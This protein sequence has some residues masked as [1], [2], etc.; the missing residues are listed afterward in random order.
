M[1]SSLET[2]ICHGC[3]PKKKKKRKRK[4]KKKI[5]AQIN[6][7]QTKKTIERSMMK[8]WFFEKIDK[9]GKTFT[10]L[11]KKK[12]QIYKIRNEEVTTDIIEIQKIIRNYYEQL[13]TNKT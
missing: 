5:T 4:E 1:T 9:I 7:I 13:Y 12:P 2:S 3:G 8:S 11:R 10:R 6:E